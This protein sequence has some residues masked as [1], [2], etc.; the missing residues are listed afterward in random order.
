MLRRINLHW[1]QQLSRMIN[2][3]EEMQKIYIAR[4]TINKSVKFPLPVR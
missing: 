2:Q 3:F 1:F 4:R